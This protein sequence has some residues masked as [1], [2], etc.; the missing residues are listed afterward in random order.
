MTG[1]RLRHSPSRSDAAAAPADDRRTRLVGGDRFHARVNLDHDPIEV[2]PLDGAVRG[3]IWNC[4]ERPR[5][6]AAVDG[7]SVVADR[8]EEVGGR[9]A[10]LRGRDD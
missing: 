1:A 4:R 9:P 6:H 3:G 8:H 2:V 5:L 7:I 10:R